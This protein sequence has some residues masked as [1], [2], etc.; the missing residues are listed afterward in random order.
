M[1]MTQLTRV[2]EDMRS[3]PI[4]IKV[5]PEHRAAMVKIDPRAY[6]PILV[7]ERKEM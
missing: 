5:L 3:R 2:K 4:M 1:T 6:S 7:L